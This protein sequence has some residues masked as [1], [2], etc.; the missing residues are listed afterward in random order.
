M[1]KEETKITPQD[2][3]D[4]EF[5]V[6]FRGFDMA[7]VDSFLEEMAENFFKLSEENLLLNEKVM[8]L[9]QDLENFSSMASRS[10]VELPAELGNTLK[11]LKQDNAAISAELA[12]LKQDRH[13]FDALREKLEQV[14]AS[15]EESRALMTSNSQVEFTAGLANTLKGFKQGSEAIG[16]EL[17]ALKEDRQALDSLKKGLEKVLVSARDA[18]P[19]IAPPG[20]TEIPG[21]LGKTLAEFKK[22]TEAIGTE[23][24]ALKQEIAAISGIGNEIKGELQELLTSRFAE[25]ETKLSLHDKAAAAAPKAAAPP[26]PSGKEKLPVARIEKEPEGSAEETRLPDYHDEDDGTSGGADLEFLS[27]DDILDVDKLRGIFQSVLDEGISDGHES[28]DGDDATADL[29]FLEEDFFEDDHEPEVTFSLDE[30][31]ADN[32][33]PIPNKREPV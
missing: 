14:M 8:A 17:A 1:E 25:L 31:E 6:K 23:L 2:I 15:I 32:K 21:D 20:R 11:D 7:E 26:A 4:K 5:R 22:G 29:L 13:I 24:A 30:N 19:T 16:A 33:K 3:I 18:A 12:A 9:Q 27:E 10:P 28:R